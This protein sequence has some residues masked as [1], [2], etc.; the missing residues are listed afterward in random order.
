MADIY[1]DDVQGD[2]SEL[3][4]GTETGRIVALGLVLASTG[5]TDA[6]D[7]SEWTT[8]TG[9]SPQ[10]AFIINNGVRGEMPRASDTEEEGFGL[11]ET[12]LTGASGSAT[13]QIKGLDGNV[14]WTNIVNKKK[15]HVALPYSAGQMLF[16][17]VPCTVVF[18]PVI[19][20]DLKST[21]YW[22]VSIKWSS[23]DNPSIVDTPTL[24]QPES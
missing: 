19:S 3:S 18:R 13:L 21:A 6:S 7:N 22:E 10:T 20:Q 9:A 4:C 5:M 12:Q 2:F 11:D 16:V 24:L 15:W 14:A 17:S 23:I 8:K 1:C